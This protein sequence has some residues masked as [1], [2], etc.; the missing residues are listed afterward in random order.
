MRNLGGATAP[1]NIPLNARGV[2]SAEMQCRVVALR[3]D[4]D[5]KIGI[6]LLPRGNCVDMTGAIRYF[7]RIDPH[8]KQIQT[9]A[10]SNPDTIYTR[11]GDEHWQTGIA[12]SWVAGFPAA[13][14]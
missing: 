9:F 3:Y 8:V 13:G 6:A 1:V 10:G 12:G 11:V 7:Q 2:R 4:P 14:R 5:S